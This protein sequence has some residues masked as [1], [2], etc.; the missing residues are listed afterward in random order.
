MLKFIKNSLIFSAGFLACGYLV[1]NAALNSADAREAAVHMM[2]KKI[3]RAIYGEDFA[4]RSHIHHI[5]FDSREDA[6]SVYDSML[7][8][9]NNYGM[10]SVA[11]YYDLA[12]QTSTYTDSRYGWFKLSGACVSRTRN[13]YEIRLPRPQKLN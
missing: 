3:S 12:G 10:V 8:C 2:T 5:V 11:D 7:T 13:G 6:E 1:A 4:D 9:L